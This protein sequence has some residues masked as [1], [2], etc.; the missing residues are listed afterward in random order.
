MNEDYLLISLVLRATLLWHPQ[1]HCGIHNLIINLSV[2]N[3]LFHNFSKLLLP[4][5]RKLLL[6]YDAKQPL[7]LLLSSG[8]D[9]ER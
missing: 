1:P 5:V 3:Q 7:L 8:I 6:P 4:Y 9:T 2:D